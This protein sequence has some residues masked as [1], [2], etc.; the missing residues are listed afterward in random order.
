MLGLAGRKDTQLLRE[1]SFAVARLAVVAAVPAAAA[2]DTVEIVEQVGSELLEMVL[3]VEPPGRCL[4]VGV[5]DTVDQK[6]NTD[7][8]EVESQLVD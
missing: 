5:F 8:G 3:A 1:V 2:V 4:V 6:V 7:S